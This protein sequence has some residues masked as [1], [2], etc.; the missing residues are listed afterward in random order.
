MP[1]ATGWQSQAPLR[2]PEHVPVT[3]GAREDDDANA[4]ESWSSRDQ[5]SITG[6]ANNR[7]LNSSSCCLASV[8]S[9]ASSSTSTALP[10]RS[11]LMPSTPSREAAPRA[12]PLQRLGPALRAVLGCDPK[13]LRRAMDELKFLRVVSGVDGA[14][15]YTEVS[16]GIGPVGVSFGQYD[17]YGDNYGISYGFS[18]GSYDCALTYSDFSD[19]GYGADEDAFVFSVSASL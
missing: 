18:C 8:A 5:S 9:A 3:V 10:I 16:Y 12:A 7:S 14:P 17:D 2:G 15:D 11:L 19:D 1:D 6:L 4:H 13:A